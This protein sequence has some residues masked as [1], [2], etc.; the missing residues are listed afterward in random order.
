MKSINDTPLPLKATGNMPYVSFLSATN[1][2]NK[3][4]IEIGTIVPTSIAIF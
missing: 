1:D 4:Q 3:A 2:L